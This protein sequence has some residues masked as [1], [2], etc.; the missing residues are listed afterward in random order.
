VSLIRHREYIRRYAMLELRHRFAGSGLG[1]L[2]LV[3]YPLALIGLYSAVFSGIM[4]VRIPE[5]AAL[6]MSFTL[7]LCSGLL[8]WL[9]FADTVTQLT[10]ALYTHGRDIV[11]TGLPE[12]VFFA[13]GAVTGY[14]T[15]LLSCGLVLVLGLVTGLQP[16]WAWLALPLILALLVAFA[17]GLGMVLGVLHV[18]S[19]DVG[20]VVAI[21]L[22]LSLWTAPIVYV[23]SVLP[24]EVRQWLP[25]NPLYPFISSLHE[26]ILFGEA[27]G[28]SAWLWMLAVAGLAIGLG[29][30]LLDATRSQVRDAL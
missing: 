20:P 1:P 4:Q 12:Q 30:A 29:Y 28:A 21:A 18:F 3:L 15:T 23:E 11:R 26:T 14:L 9:G 22:Q 17:A 25:W 2:W 7:Y 16:S 10:G 5:L 13:K 6:P 8:P 19:R 24:A 27:P